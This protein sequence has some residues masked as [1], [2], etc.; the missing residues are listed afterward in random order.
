MST[1]STSS[2][3]SNRTIEGLLNRIRAEY[4]ELPGLTLTAW[5]AQRLWGAAG[6]QCEP[7]L[8]AL[9]DASFLTRTKEGAYVR[10]HH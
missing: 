5:Q 8:A 4:T 7:V 3:H 10:A 1:L 2:G 9:V 6:I